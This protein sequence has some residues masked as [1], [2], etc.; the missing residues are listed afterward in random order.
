MELTASLSVIADVNS[1]HTMIG[2][3]RKTESF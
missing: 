2:K 1:L 3:M